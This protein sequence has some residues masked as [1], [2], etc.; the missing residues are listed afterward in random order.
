[1]QDCVR[2]DNVHAH[3]PT[4][5]HA[6]THARTGTCTHKYTD[7]TKLNTQLKWTT[8][9]DV[10]SDPV[11]TYSSCGDGLSTAALPRIQKTE[12]KKKSTRSWSRSQEQVIIFMTKLVL[13]CDIP[14]TCSF[15]VVV[16]V[17][18]FKIMNASSVPLL[19]VNDFHHTCNLEK[20]FTSKK[21]KTTTL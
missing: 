9:R 13:C 1:M 10:T 14:C 11:G 15:V 6:R 21:Q 12:A 8:N 20:H 16:D 18:V 4:R 2:G 19:I 3:M 5:T 7:Y 17:I